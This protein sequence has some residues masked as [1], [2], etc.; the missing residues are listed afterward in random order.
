MLLPL[1]SAYGSHECGIKL[2]YLYFFLD[3]S[4]QM[5]KIAFLFNYHQPGNIRF[6]HYLQKQKLFRPKI[7]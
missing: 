6:E 3:K 5:N 1:F 4:S 2:Y 7:N